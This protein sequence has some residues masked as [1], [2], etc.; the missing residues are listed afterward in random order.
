MVLV[1]RTAGGMGAKLTAAVLTILLLCGCSAKTVY[2]PYALQEDGSHRL[3]MST[4][5]SHQVLEYCDGTLDKLS[6]GEL[7]TYHGT[8]YA[9]SNYRVYL[10]NNGFVE[11][12]YEATSSVLNS[13]L[14]NGSEKVRLIYQSSGT[15]RIVMENQEGLAHI[16]LGGM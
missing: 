11:T 8:L 9:L 7:S 15:I 1:R 3:P 12:S 13:L 5:T 14:D 4:Y 6:K 2:V 16:L 10:M